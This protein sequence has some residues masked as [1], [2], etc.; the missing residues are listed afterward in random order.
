MFVHRRCWSPSLNQK[1]KRE[2]EEVE[3]GIEVDNGVLVREDQTSL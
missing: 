3:R 1:G 2:G